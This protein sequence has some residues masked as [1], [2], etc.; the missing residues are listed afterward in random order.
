MK[1]SAPQEEQDL[2]GDGDGESHRLTQVFHLEV[3]SQGTGQSS[4]FVSETGRAK[5]LMA[6]VRAML[7]L[8]VDVSFSFQSSSCS[9]SPVSLCVTLTLLLCTMSEAPAHTMQAVPIQQ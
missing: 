8:V 6:F 1:G 9:I 5:W 4:C 3:I 7:L 2:G